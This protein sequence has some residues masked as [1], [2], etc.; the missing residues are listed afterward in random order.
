MTEDITI[1]I[2]F[3]VLGSVLLLASSSGVLEKNIGS[4]LLMNHFS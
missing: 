2:S 4:V 3:D 1:K